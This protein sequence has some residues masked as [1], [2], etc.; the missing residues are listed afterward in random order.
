MQ[1][2]LENSYS[3]NSYVDQQVKYKFNLRIFSLRDPN[4][5]CIK[6]NPRIYLYTLEFWYKLQTMSK[7]P[8]IPLF[9]TTKQA[10]HLTRMPR[11]TLDYLV[12]TELVKPSLGLAEP[13]R[14]IGRRY[15][16]GDL[17]L[18]RAV[19]QLVHLGVSITRLKQAL[20]HLFETHHEITPGTIP[21]RYLVTD[22]TNVYFRTDNHS[23]ESLNEGGQLAFSFILE[24]QNY[25]D[26]ILDE[27]QQP[28]FQQIG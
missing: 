2:H 23:I 10:A 15:S 13:K 6:N 12:R 7:P 28:G 8:D 3:V 19:A 9:Y 14:G 11:T 24:I 22:G 26:Q 21:G 5:N 27:V 20:K 17:V 16:F 4:H 1:T 18:L 25:R